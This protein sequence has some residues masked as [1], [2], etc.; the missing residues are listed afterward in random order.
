MDKYIEALN[1]LGCKA[2]TETSQCN[3]NKNKKWKTCLECDF[4]KA[5]IVLE[6][7][8]KNYTN[9]EDALERACV[10]ISEVYDHASASEWKEALLNDE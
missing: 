3:A 7:L 4:I 2:L 10:I 8:V 1:T 6:D 5:H 9:L